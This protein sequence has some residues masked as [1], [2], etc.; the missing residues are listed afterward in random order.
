MKSLLNLKHSWL[1]HNHFL[2]RHYVICDKWSSRE[3]IYCTAFNYQGGLNKIKSWA[4]GK[5]KILNEWLKCIHF[6]PSFLR[7]IEVKGR[8]HQFSNLIHS[9]SQCRVALFSILSN[10]TSCFSKEPPFTPKPRISVVVLSKLGA[11][12][13]FL[14]FSW[15]PPGSAV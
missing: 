8:F 14:Y 6:M 12:L 1:I 5:E 11:V 4:Y 15:F 10:P 3:E 9:V 2:L 13:T 7:I